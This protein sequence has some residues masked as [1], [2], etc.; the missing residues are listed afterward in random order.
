MRRP[1]I[2]VC[3][4]LLAS[5]RV[6]ADDLP[7]CSDLGVRYSQPEITALLGGVGIEKIG[8]PIEVVDGR[9]IKGEI[10]SRWQGAA[11]FYAVQPDFMKVGPWDSEIH[12][13]GRSTPRSSWRLRVKDHGNNPVELTWLNEELLFFRIWWNRVVSLDTIRPQAH[14]GILGGPERRDSAGA[15]VAGWLAE[16]RDGLTIR[17]PCARSPG[18]CGGQSTAKNPHKNRHTKAYRQKDACNPLILVGERDSNPRP[19]HYECSD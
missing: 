2:C 10:A 17:S 11:Y 12:I 18:C 13:Y 14:V 6:H 8:V 16:L 1:F 3:V 5:T 7:M 9:L 19:R 4:A 15:D